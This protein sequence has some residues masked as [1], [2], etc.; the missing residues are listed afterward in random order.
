MVKKKRE[1]KKSIEKMKKEKMLP[2]KCELDCKNMT[3]Y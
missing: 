3:R 1:K 2:Y